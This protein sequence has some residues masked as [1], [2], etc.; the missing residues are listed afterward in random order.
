MNKKLQWGIATVLIAGAITAPFALDGSEQNPDTS[1]DAPG[2]PQV[3]KFQLENV[4]G[5]LKINVAELGPDTGQHAIGQ[6]GVIGGELQFEAWTRIDNNLKGYIYAIP[7]GNNSNVY[8]EAMAA[9]KDAMD[10][11]HR[12]RNKPYSVWLREEYDMWWSLPQVKSILQSWTC[13]RFQRRL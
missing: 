5:A 4:N 12:P 1:T 8:D 2:Q 13:N 3:A 9:M 7:A 6:I 10:R 11:S